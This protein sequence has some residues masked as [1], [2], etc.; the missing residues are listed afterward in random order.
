MEGKHNGQCEQ[1]LTPCHNDHGH[2]FL[3]VHFDLTAILLNFS[4]TRGKA[5]DNFLIVD[6][7]FFSFQLDCDW[8]CGWSSVT[9]FGDFSTL[10]QN[11]KIF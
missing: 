6:T 9:R 7:N 1:V 3:E 4:W 2:A 10:W 5:V 11:L 8:I